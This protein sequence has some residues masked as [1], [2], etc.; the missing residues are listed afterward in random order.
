MYR[1][2]IVTEN[3]AVTD[4]ITAMQGWEKL[5]FKAP[6][7][8]STADEAVA[9]MQKHHIDAVAVDPTAVFEGFAAYLDQQYPDVPMFQ[10]ASDEQ[11][12]RVIMQELSSLL[13]RINAD[14]SNDDL[15]TAYQMQVQRERWMKKLIS[16]MVA[17][18][19]QLS[20]QL[21]LYR[22]HAQINVPC[23]LARLEMSDED[24]FMS[25]RW[26]YGSD[27]LE[28]ALRNFFGRGHSHMLMHVAV[29]SPEEVRVLCYPESQDHC[30]SE[31]IAYDYMH[32]TLE[33][34]ENYLGLHMNILNV[35]RLSGL[36]EL[37][38]GA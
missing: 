29:I 8:R 26:H 2:L 28:T 7:L 16:G 9:C 31:N 37:C 12:Q 4:M 5:G 14:D 15:D 35:C 38:A 21:N 34:I 20:R 6:R 13:A 17:S 25:E 1:L 24:G 36:T 3:Q 18:E 11:T 19:E 10:I 22:I 30:V 32:E 27:R 23:V 33:Q